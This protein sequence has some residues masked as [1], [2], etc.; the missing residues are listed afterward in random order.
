MVSVA[1]AQ[2]SGA[3]APPPAATILPLLLVVAIFYLLVFRP[4]QRKRREHDQMVAG[5]K[6]NDRVT[7]SSG[8]RGRVVAVGEQTVT[9]EIAPKV[10]VDFDRSAVQQV[11]L[12]EAREK[13]QGKS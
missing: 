2:E 11:H 3:G 5:L 1:M 12:P 6:R 13:E 9:V 10:H 7:M 8:M 4:E